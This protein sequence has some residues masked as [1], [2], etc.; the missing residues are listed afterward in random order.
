[1]Y[2]GIGLQ[3]ARGSGTNGYV[4]RNI[5]ALRFQNNKKSYEQ[6]DKEAEL[7]EQR[8]GRAPNRDLQKN[9]LKNG[10]KCQKVKCKKNPNIGENRAF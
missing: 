2:N 9:F 10:L 1:M 6:V 3:T 7:F 5:S 8:L 4:Q